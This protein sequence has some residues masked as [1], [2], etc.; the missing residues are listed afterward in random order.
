M[1]TRRETEF[2]FYYLCVKM[3]YKG[4]YYGKLIKRRFTME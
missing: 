1:Y 3:I 2:A 4:D